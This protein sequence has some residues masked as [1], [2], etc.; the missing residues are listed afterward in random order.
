VVGASIPSYFDGILKVRH[1]F[2]HGFPVPMDV[3][4]L[5][6]PGVLDSSFV[7]DAITCLEFFASTTDNLL[8]H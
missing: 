7:S 1:S 8:E 6:A 2:A 5:Q 4:G 3:P